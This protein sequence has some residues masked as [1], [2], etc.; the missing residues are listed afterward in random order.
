M[1]KRFQQGFISLDQ[2]KQSSALLKELYSSI[3]NPDYISGPYGYFISRGLTKADIH[4]TDLFGFF[5]ATHKPSHKKCPIDKDGRIKKNLLHYNIKDLV[6]LYEGTLATQRSVVAEAFQW[7]S[8]LCSL[9]YFHLSHISRRYKVPPH[10]MDILNS[11]IVPSKYKEVLNKKR[12]ALR[13]VAFIVYEGYGLSGYSPNLWTF[14]CLITGKGTYTLPDKESEVPFFIN[15]AEGYAF[16]NALAEEEDKYLQTRKEAKDKSSNISNP[17]LQL[18]QQQWLSLDKTILD[19]YLEHDGNKVNIGYD[20]IRELYNAWAL[21]NIYRTL[22]R[23]KFVE[24]PDED[25][26]LAILCGFIRRSAKGKILNGNNS[27][28]TDIN[29]DLLYL[30][31]YEKSQ[32]VSVNS[33]GLNIDI[34]SI[35]ESTKGKP[36]PLFLYMQYYWETMRSAPNSLYNKLCDDTGSLIP[37]GQ[38]IDDLYESTKERLTC[39]RQISYRA[40]ALQEAQGDQAT[41]MISEWIKSGAQFRL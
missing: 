7:Y 6:G 19:L 24:A 17:A 9:Y 1:N 21:T 5:E 37:F 28:L 16:S 3:D 29:F 15:D 23:G 12:I 39:I 27:S 35:A 4:K 20:L 36:T 2:M 34:E 30:D 32:I 10:T 40:K 22:E 14:F 31:E 33:E 11:S 8:C 41:I 38:L 13:Y 26:Q 25:L 18:F